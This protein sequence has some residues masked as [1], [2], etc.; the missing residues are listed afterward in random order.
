MQIIF[1]ILAALNLLAFMV[2]LVLGFIGA[3]YPWFF[4]Y[5]VRAGLLTALFTCGVHSIIFTHFIGSG[6]S[7][8]EVVLANNLG[9]DYIQ[10]TRFFKSKVFP[11]AFFSI[12]LT[13]G[14]VATGSAA[15]TVLIRS[16]I[17]TIFAVLTVVL[18]LIT[19]FVEH[20]Y[21]GENARLLDRVNFAL[22]EQ[23]LLDSS[24]ES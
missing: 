13:I 14:V 10:K 8:K 3:E 15:H 9:L 2:T 17:H 12:L 16:G 1:I 6:L 22:V 5:H 24:P 23:E 21:I 20:R 11:F 4:K 7:V 19:F 18:N